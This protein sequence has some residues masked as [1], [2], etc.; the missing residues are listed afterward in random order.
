MGILQVVTGVYR[1]LQV[2]CVPSARA[3]RMRLRKQEPCEVRMF[4]VMVQTSIFL[5]LPV[6]V[7]YRGRAGPVIFWFDME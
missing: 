5:I 1:W 2:L 7:F 4:G 6:L 3:R